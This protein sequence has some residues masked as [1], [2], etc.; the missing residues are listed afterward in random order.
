MLFSKSF[1][2]ALRGILYIAVVQE[3]KQRVPLEEIADKVGAPKHFMGKVLKRLVKE[4][5]LNSVKGPTGGFYLREK[6]LSTPVLT[7]VAITDG[8]AGFKTCVLRFVECNLQNPCPMHAKVE[9]TIKELKEMIG[10]TTVGELLTNDKERLL[11]SIATVN[12]V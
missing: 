4:N 3:E 6:T 1:S 11:A 10:E 2:Y 9:A 12:H 5:I 8:L 7:I